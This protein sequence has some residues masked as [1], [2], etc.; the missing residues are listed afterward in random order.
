MELMTVVTVSNI[1]D[2]DASTAWSPEDRIEDFL[3]DFSTDLTVSVGVLLRQYGLQA[4]IAVIS[5]PTEGII[6]VNS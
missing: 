3:K 4:D 1:V 2:D 5:A 6:G